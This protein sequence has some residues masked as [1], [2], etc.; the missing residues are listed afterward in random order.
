MARISH[1][2]PLQQI[3]CYLCV[4]R[5]AS[6]V[7]GVLQFLS[8][9]DKGPVLETAKLWNGGVD[10]TPVHFIL[11]RQDPWVPADKAVAS[12][13]E[14]FPF[15][16]VSEWD[17]GHVLHEANPGRFNAFLDEFLILQ[18]IRPIQ[19]KTT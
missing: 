19:T 1:F 2:C 5:A 17:G 18:D 10:S 12:I 11:G 9:W 8:S 6:H 7:S 4:H 13:R 3:V 16:H 15:A 14:N